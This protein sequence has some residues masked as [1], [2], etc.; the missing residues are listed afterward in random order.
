MRL[1]WKFTL[2]F[3][4]S[5]CVVLT[6]YAW[7]V[8]QREILRLRQDT[9]RD[10]AVLGYALLLGVEQEWE[11]G[12]EAAAMEFVRR[13]D[14]SEARNRV[15]V[16][17]VWLDPPAGGAA[18]PVLLP[19]RLA[20]L[21]AGERVAWADRGILPFGFHYT[22]TPL[23]VSD[24]RLGAIEVRES[25]EDEVFYARNTIRGIVLATAAVV[26]IVALMSWRLGVRLVGRPVA[27]LISQARRV[28][29]GTFDRLPDLGHHDELAELGGELNRMCDQLAE[30]RD[31]V[32]AETAARIRM[33]EQ[34]RHADRLKTIGQLSSGIAHELGTPL[35]VVRARA[36]MVSTDP[37]AP[38]E[39]RSNARIVVEQSDQMTRIIRQLLDFARQRTP[40]RMRVDLRTVVQ[41]T[42]DLLAAVTGKYQTRLVLA[43]GDTPM[44]VDVDSDQLQQV[45]SNLVMNGMQAMPDGGELIVGLR[46]ERTR[47]PDKP[48][49]P[50]DDWV[51][52]YVKDGGHGIK[53]EDL[54]RIFDPFFS[55]KPASEGTGL[56]LSVS[57]GIIE[58]HGGWIGVTSE[59]GRGSCFCVYLP[60]SAGDA[61][62]VVDCG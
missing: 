19:K 20:M 35:N 5:L 10:Q 29:S 51:C 52:L 55:T 16:R 31:R 61:A 46:Q 27:M 41:R 53:T 60:R 58:E 40:R 1:A 56:G 45:L 6:V 14:R 38:E 9:E 62:A 26:G 50:E 30:A 39:A 7:L 49:L 13:A 43:V 28:A 18:G 59:V 21:K 37:A 4:V 2:V 36:K 42:I 25:L 32:N 12:G 11:R 33:L 24:G 48:M 54:D 22:Y 15:S 44:P 23:R 57:R 8:C 3:V 47:H 34:L 17:W